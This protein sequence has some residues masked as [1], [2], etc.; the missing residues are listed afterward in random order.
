MSTT[1]RIIRLFVVGVIA[2]LYFT[3]TVAGLQGYALLVVGIIFLITSLFGS[4]PLYSL[5]GISS[6]K[7]KMKIE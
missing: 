1:D 3:G 6:C 7:V 2:G 5:F 4:C